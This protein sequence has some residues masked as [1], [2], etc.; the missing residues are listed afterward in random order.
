MKWTRLISFR[1]RQPIC[2]RFTVK[3]AFEKSYYVYC[4]E[5]VL[6]I[7][8]IINDLQ[9]NYFDKPFDNLYLKQTHRQTVI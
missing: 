8:D 9:P 2:T 4:G 3:C 5:T 1:L 6:V 7:L